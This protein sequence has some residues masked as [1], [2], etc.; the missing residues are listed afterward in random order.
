ML[1]AVCDAQYCFTLVDI[2]DSGRHSDGGVFQNSMIGRKFE[3]NTLNIPAPTAIISND[4]QSYVIPYFFAAD[5]AFP[6]KCG[7]V[8]PYPGRFLSREKQIF[9]YRLSR[10]RRVIE[11]A[12]GILAARWQIFCVLM[13]CNPECAEV[14]VQACV[15]LHNF[16]QKENIKLPIHN[17]LYCSTVDVDHM[18]KSGV[19][20]PGN[21]RYTVPSGNINWHNIGR[22]GSNFYSRD[23]G[24]IRDIMCEYFSSP[25]G[26][27]PWQ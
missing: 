8:K 27:V 17:R 25:S 14:I 9:N 18:D 1:L 6:L 26:A 20:T 2:G 24:A 7:I 19:I 10:A 11:N 4:P 13:K 15:A 22:F 12:F 21:W 16:L 23:A 3:D 5:D